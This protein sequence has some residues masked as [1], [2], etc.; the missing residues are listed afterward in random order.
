MSGLGKGD[1]RRRRLAAGKGAVRRAG[2]VRPPPGALRLL[3]ADR[4]PPLR[5]CRLPS[6]RGSIEYRVIERAVSE[7]RILTPAFLKLRPR[8]QPSRSRSNRASKSAAVTEGHAPHSSPTLRRCRVCRSRPWCAE[9]SG[10][11]RSE[12]L[13][14]ALV[15]RSGREANHDLHGPGECQTYASW[16]GVT[17]SAEGISPAFEMERRDSRRTRSP[18]AVV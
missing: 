16:P 9:R 10:A 18:S 12:K 1:P 15:G 5:R 14:A 13:S 3:A 6:F 17:A 11:R 4:P 2:A 7:A 8:M